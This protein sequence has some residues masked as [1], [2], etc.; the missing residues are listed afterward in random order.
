M[1]MGLAQVA[2]FCAC[3]SLHFAHLSELTIFEFSVMV[4]NLH[5]H[6]HVEIG[7]VPKHTLLYSILKY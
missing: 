6:K 3:E 1:G 4:I 2:I 7:V 5:M